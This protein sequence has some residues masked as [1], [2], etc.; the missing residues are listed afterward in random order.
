MLEPPHGAWVAET[1]VDVRSYEL[2]SFA[3]VNHAVFLNYLE[4]ARFDTLRQGGF[5]Y[6]EIIARGWGVYVVRIEIDYLKEARLGDTLRIRTWAHAQ[7]RSSLV[8]AQVIVRHDDP[9]VVVARA[10]VTAVWVDNARR[11]MRVPAE[12]TEAFR[13][14]P[15]RTPSQP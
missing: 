7:K 14:G 3:H 2:D 6:Q 8:L 10:L 4:Y 11:P 9:D 1:T 5:P 12:V 13:V 15:G